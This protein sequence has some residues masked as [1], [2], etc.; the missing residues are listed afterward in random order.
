M[1]PTSFDEMLVALQ[2]PGAVALL[3]W[4]ASWALD[5]VAGWQALPAKVKSLS[6]LG[7]AIVLG[8]GSVWFSGHPAWVAAAEPYIKSVL[9]V[10]AA[11]L[12]LQVAHKADK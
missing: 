5:D 6:I 11:W 9:A 8:I 1:F 10:C 7:L 3:V 4:F 2:G 12:A